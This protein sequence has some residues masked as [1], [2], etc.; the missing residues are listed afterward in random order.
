MQSLKQSLNI[1]LMASLGVNTVID[2][3]GNRIT[4]VNNP[5]FDEPRTNLLPPFNYPMIGST[6]RVT[7]HQDFWEELFANASEMPANHPKDLIKVIDQEDRYYKVCCMFVHEDLFE[8][9]FE[10]EI[11]CGVNDP[12]IPILD[13]RKSLV[14]SMYTMADFGISITRPTTIMKIIKT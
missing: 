10:I 9:I 7:V 1:K 11:E 12:S 5:Y 8:N 3:S 6:V 14:S 2:P 13:L 4:W